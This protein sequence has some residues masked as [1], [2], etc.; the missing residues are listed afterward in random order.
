VDG[1]L[2]LQGGALI[3]RAYGFALNGDPASVAL[4]KRM[5]VSICHPMY[6]VLHRWIVHGEL[7]DTH[8]EFFVGI[9]QEVSINGGNLWHDLYFIRSSMLPKFVSLELA[10]KILVIGKSIN[11]L[12]ACDHTGA[13][14]KDTWKGSKKSKQ[15]AIKPSPARSTESAGP[16][17]EESLLE[18]DASLKAIKFGDEAKLEEVVSRIAVQTDAKLLKV[19]ME[20]AHLSEHLLALKKFML[21]GQVSQPSLCASFSSIQC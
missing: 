3:S 9:N 12:R 8:R 19:M 14:D 2:P 6:A 17:S 11:F 1:A 18:L 15:L 20:K 16:S 13:W 10:Q 7:I 5:M 4:V 21:L